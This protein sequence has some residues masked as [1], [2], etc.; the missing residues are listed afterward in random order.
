[1]LNLTAADNSEDLSLTSKSVNLQ[2]Q[3]DEEKTESLLTDELIV[4]NTFRKRQ[5]NRVVNISAQHLKRV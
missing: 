4:I 3:C 1:M 2:A 5:R